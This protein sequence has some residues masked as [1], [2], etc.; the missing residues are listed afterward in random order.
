MILPSYG[1]R[2]KGFTLIELLIVI[3]IIGVLSSILMSSFIGVRERARDGRRKSD[4]S[5]IQAALEQ[6]RADQAQY[7]ASGNGALGCGSTLVAGSS[8]F[9]QK[10][11]CDPLGS[12]Q[13]IYNGGTYW[14]W[15]DTNTYYLFSCLENSSDS[16]GVGS[17]DSRFTTTGAPTANCPSSKYYIIQ[18][19]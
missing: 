8:T 5:Q 15:S 7:P 12:G 3:A 17:S 1:P 19:P 6:Y 10:V 4:L 9:M 16:Q 18:N 13:S 2:V 11:P 14:Y